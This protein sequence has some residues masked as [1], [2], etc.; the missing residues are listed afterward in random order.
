MLNSSSKEGQPHQFP[1]AFNLIEQ[2][3]DAEHPSKALG[4]PRNP[5]AE[6][7]GSENDAI[8]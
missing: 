8:P 4:A 2:L 3:L 1:A 6:E 5:K 7:D